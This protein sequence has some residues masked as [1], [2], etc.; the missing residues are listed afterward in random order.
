MSKITSREQGFIAY[1][2]S[3]VNNKDRGA[4]A[5]LRRGLGKSPGTVPQM[6]RYV[7]K[8][9]PEDTELGQEEPYYLV[10]SLF[11]FWHQ[12]RDSP[13]S[14]EGNLAR[15]L[16]ALVEQEQDSNKRDNLEKSTEKRLV[17]LL[18]CHR[19]DLPEHLRQIVSLLQSKD[20]PVD[21]AQL[22]SDIKHW[23][24]DD[25]PVQKA[26]ARGFWIGS[27]Q[28]EENRGAHAEVSTSKADES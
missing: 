23:E 11:A 17:A 26:W 4:I 1:L 14:T 16:R 20:A 8:F 21:W 19:D 18:N 7:L 27:R 15:S 22:L 6:D 13:E 25:R 10:A 9:L 2:E 24:R 28:R 3:L 12:G 5:N